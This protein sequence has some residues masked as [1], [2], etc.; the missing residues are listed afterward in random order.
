M[1]Q[2]VVLIF[3]GGEKRA[4]DSRPTCMKAAED[5]DRNPSNSFAFS[6]RLFFAL[7]S[8]TAPTRVKYVCFQNLLFEDAEMGHL[9]RGEDRGRWIS[10]AVPPSVV[11]SGASNRT[12]LRRW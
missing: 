6:R 3:I 5:E 9:I 7:D 1:L 10:R 4:L 11:L 2:P 8:I 12:E